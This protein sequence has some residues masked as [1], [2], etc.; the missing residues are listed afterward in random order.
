M[1]PISMQRLKTPLLTSRFARVFVQRKAVWNGLIHPCHRLYSKS[2]RVGQRS[3]R[4]VL[5]MVTGSAFPSVPTLTSL[6][7]RPRRSNRKH[8]KD[9]ILQRSTAYVSLVVHEDEALA[10]KLA[11]PETA[12]HAHIMAFQR[13]QPYPLQP[14][15]EEVIS[16]VAEVS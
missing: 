7:G 3:W 11:A 5:P 2:L 14:G 13:N 1:S 16:R 8:L 12:M 4:L 15:E 10:C 9:V 6:R